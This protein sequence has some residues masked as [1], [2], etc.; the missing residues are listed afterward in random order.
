VA[1]YLERSVD[2][3]VALL[4][5][6]KAGGAY[7][8]LETTHPKGRVQYVLNDARTRVILAQQ[9]TAST[10][11]E[12]HAQVICLDSDWPRIAAEPVDVPATT[13]TSEN[14]AYV[15]YTSGS[16]G[17]ARGVMVQHRSVVN[18]A[19]ALRERVYPTDTAPLRVSVNAPLMFDS[20]VKQLVQLLYG[21]ELC[22]VPEDVRIDGDALAAYIKGQGIDVLDCTPSQL[23]LLLASGLFTGA[24]QAPGLVLIGGEAIDEETW[25]LLAS[26]SQT[27][28]F[29]VYGPTEC[30]VDTTVHCIAPA[31]TGLRPPRLRPTRLRLTSH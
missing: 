19:A 15:I 9:R 22:V 17:G 31:P 29:N 25:Q 11:P 3:I 23:R 14:L 28:F 24:S 12:H 2:M 1:L 21:H 20:S 27:T 8:P 7:L 26:A 10:L 5:V 30:T 6:L 13:V 16:T 4:G 18:L